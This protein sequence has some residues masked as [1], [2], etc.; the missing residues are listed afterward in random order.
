MAEHEAPA[1]RAT[2]WPPPLAASHD[3]LGSRLSTLD[4]RLSTLDSRLSALGSRH[5]VL[6]SRY[7]ASMC[8]ID[9]DRPVRYSLRDKPSQTDSSSPW[10][11]RRLFRL[12]VDPDLESCEPIVNA[13]D[14]REGRSRQVDNSPFYIGT[15]IID[16][17]LNGFS[18]THIIDDDFCPERQGLVRCSQ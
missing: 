12:F 4:S 17:D 3:A 14:L 15:P 10:A 9:G 16:S 8:I 6:R 2:N 1:R 11:S 7:D 18:V 5:S 13:G